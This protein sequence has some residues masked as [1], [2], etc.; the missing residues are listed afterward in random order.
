MAKAALKK[1]AVNSDVAEVYGKVADLLDN[2]RWYELGPAKER[3][4]AVLVL[5]GTFQDRNVLIAKMAIGAGSQDRILI[6]PTCKELKL[7]AASE[8][9]RNG[10]HTGE[11]LYVMMNDPHML[12]YTPMKIGAK[13][14]FSSKALSWYPEAVHPTSPL[15]PGEFYVYSNR[16]FAHGDLV[17]RVY[18]PAR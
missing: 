9:M 6:E 4:G 1:A 3:Y 12:K 18:S 2:I 13:L 8:I 17:V 11:T 5:G 7:P 15:Q 10:R 14:V 16:D